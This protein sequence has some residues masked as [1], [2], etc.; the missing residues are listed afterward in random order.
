MKELENKFQFPS[1]FEL[2][3]EM[4]ISNDYNLWVEECL[5]SLFASKPRKTKRTLGVNAALQ[6]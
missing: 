1:I 2:I 6:A 4:K 3:L 5:G